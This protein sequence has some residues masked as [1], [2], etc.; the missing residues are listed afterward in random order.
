MRIVITGATGMIGTALCSSLL[1]GGHSITALVR[2]PARAKESAIPGV[3]Y[4]A[5]NAADKSETAT[6]WK[7]SVANADA[8]INLAGE[9]L[10]GKRWNAEFKQTLRDSRIKTT[11]RLV[12]TIG[13]SAA[14]GKNA[15]ILISTSAVG[16]YGDC[17]NQTVTE[18]NGAGSDFLSELC[19][20][21]EKEAERAE[22]FS[23]RVVLIRLGL[24][25][26]KSGMLNQLMYPLP[27]PI[28]PFKLGL[29]GPIG[30]GKQWWPWVHIDDVIGMIIWALNTETVSG[31]LNVTAPNPV[32]NTEFSNALGRELRR[33]AVIPIPAFILRQIVGEFSFA[34]LTGQRAIPEKPERLGYQ[35]A[36]KDLQAALHSLL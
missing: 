34:L 9:S 19:Q 31:A 17:G 32:T 15:P 23:S 18:N 14:A 3:T 27:I 30:N 12:D 25:L 11:R 20:D 4:V 16:Y 22:A 21:W 5:F 1:T 36:Y 29:G 6:V 13:E 10:G 33:P 35:F 28:S 7:Q 26:A 24:V 8:I 2:D